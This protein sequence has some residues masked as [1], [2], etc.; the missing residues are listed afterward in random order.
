MHVW[1]ATYQA[2][3]IAALSAGAP[4]LDW[5]EWPDDMAMEK[6]AWVSEGAAEVQSRLP[7]PTDPA[8]RAWLLGVITNETV[9]AI[10]RCR[11]ANLDPAQ[12]VTVTIYGG[13]PLAGLGDH[14]LAV[15]RYEADDRA[16]GGSRAN[17]AMGARQAVAAAMTAGQRTINSIRA[18]VEARFGITVGPDRVRSVMRALENS[19]RESGDDI[20]A[21]FRAVAKRA[22][23]YL[24]AAKGDL[25]T[26][27]DQ[28]VAAKDWTAAE[29]LQAQTARPPAMAG[30]GAA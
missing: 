24:H 25:E 8:I 30:P 2:S 27:L 14:G 23:S 22:D 5:P 26:A 6:A 20:E 29:L 13:V 16:L 7:L 12:A 15:E 9:Q 17:T 4:A 18:W 19:A 10:G 21:V 1:R 11:G 28:A 3:R